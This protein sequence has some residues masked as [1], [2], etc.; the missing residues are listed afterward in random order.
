MCAVRSIFSAI[1]MGYRVRYSHIDEDV[2]TVKYVAAT[3]AD[4]EKMIVLV[5]ASTFHQPGLLTTAI[6]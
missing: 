3:P 6:I 1:I 2:N 5:I 4:Q